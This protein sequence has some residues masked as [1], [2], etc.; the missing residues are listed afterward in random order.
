MSDG[1]FTEAI[2]RARPTAVANRVGYDP[3]FL[4]PHPIT[5]PRKRDA[6]D[7]VKFTDD[8]GKRRS[9]LRYTNFSVVMSASRR[10]CFFSAC[11]V[12]G[13]G[14]PETAPRRTPWRFDPRIDVNLQIGDDV[15][16]TKTLDDYRFARGHMTRRID[17]AW[18]DAD[19]IKAGNSDSMFVPNACPQDQSFNA[20][21]WK[22]L[23][24]KILASAVADGSRIS[25][26]TGPVLNDADP[27]M[28][29]IQ[30]PLWYWKLV[31]WIS[32]GDLQAVAY[33]QS[34]KAIMEANGFVASVVGL[35]GAEGQTVR[36]STLS[37]MV[38]INFG[39]LAAA[40]IISN[41]RAPVIDVLNTQYFVN[42]ILLPGS[43]RKHG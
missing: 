24:D 18:G 21:L 28:F 1:F 23:E 15:Y 43:A 2:S 14:V 31:A 9:E 33:M 30:I 5:L 3:Y 34:Q 10:M 37:K 4:Q 26:F 6:S 20:G 7:V 38:G 39:P 13:A 27:T 11:N 41:S 12:D 25:V 36:I 35:T 8:D 32:N 17:A 42:H 22:T 40:D 19:Q 29:G 16:G